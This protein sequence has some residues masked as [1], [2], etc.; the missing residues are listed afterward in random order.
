[1]IHS[2]SRPS[3]AVAN[4]LDL[5][6]AELLDNPHAVQEENGIAPDPDLS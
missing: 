1:M 3:A 5:S 4:R 2:A 6:E